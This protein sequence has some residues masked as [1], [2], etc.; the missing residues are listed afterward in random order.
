MNTKI[1]WLPIEDWKVLKVI[2][3]EDSSNWNYFS[4]YVYYLRTITPEYDEKTPDFIDQLIL[5]AIL[6]VFPTSRLEFNRNILFKDQLKDT[7]VRFNGNEDLNFKITF[8]PYIPNNKIDQ[9]RRME[10]YVYTFEM[11]FFR[12][13]LNDP[14]KIKFINTHVQAEIPFGKISDFNKAINYIKFKH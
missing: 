3:V 14:D 13:S 6:E 8:V 5:N 1:E 10:I 12:T 9:I 7:L 11:N 2:K 4:G